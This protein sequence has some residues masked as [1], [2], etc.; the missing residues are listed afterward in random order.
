MKTIL[1]FGDSN[2]WGYDPTA[3]AGA[4][5]PMRHAWEVRWTGVAQQMLGEDYRLVEEGLNGRTTVH[6][7][8]LEEGRN[9]RDYLVPC[10]HSHKPIGAVVLMLGTN[11]LKAR[12]GLPAGDVAEGAAQLVQLIQRSPVGKAQRAPAVLLVC[13]PVVTDL[14]HLP[15]LEDKFREAPEKSLRLPALYEAWARQLDCAFLD[16]QKV[17]STSLRDGLHLEAS[18][19]RKLGEAI[20]AAIRQIV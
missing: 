4:P 2:T 18:E 1:C 7:D 15:L 5:A 20:A 16:S 11:D 12:F 10:L 6:Q 13:P 19:H 9:G 8:P 14:Q 17:V 3:S